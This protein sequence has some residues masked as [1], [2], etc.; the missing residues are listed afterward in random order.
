[1]TASRQGNLGEGTQLST[2]TVPS[3]NCSP[4]RELHSRT[5]AARRE[6][7]PE[8]PRRRRRSGREYLL[9]AS[10]PDAQ[11][12]GHSAPPASSAP[13]LTRPWRPANAEAVPSPAR[14]RG[15]ERGLAPTEFGGGVFGMERRPRAREKGGGRWRCSQDYKRAAPAAW[16]SHSLE[17]GSTPGATAKP[18]QE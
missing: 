5:G 8:S 14:A 10:A 16:C 4:A 7:G 3:G 2:P 6:G 18:A 9:P 17:S 13:R 1:M 11:S 15:A 12:A